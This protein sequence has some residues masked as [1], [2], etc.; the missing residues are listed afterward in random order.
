MLDTSRAP[1]LVMIVGPPA[2]G[3]MTVGHALVARTRLRRLRRA[4]CL[5]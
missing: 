4:L 1:M 3:K 2:V 5:A